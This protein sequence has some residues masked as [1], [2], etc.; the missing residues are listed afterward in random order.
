MKSLVKLILSLGIKLAFVALLIAIAMGLSSCSGCTPSDTSI[1]LAIN[2]NPDITEESVKENNS[3]PVET[4]VSSLK[5]NESG[6]N[7]T[8]NNT[9]AKPTE[10][11]EQEPRNIETVSNNQEENDSDSAQPRMQDSATP[12]PTP[13]AADVSGQSATPT[14][15][16][17]A[18][19]TPKPTNTPVPTATP[20]TKPTSTPV[21][22]ATPTPEPTEAPEPTPQPPVAARIRVTLRVWGSDD[23]DGED[24]DISVIVYR[25]YTVQPK[26]GCT[27]HSYNTGNYVAPDMQI[28]TSDINS[29]FYAQY[30]NGLAVGYA[31]IGDEIVGFV[32]D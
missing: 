10:Q 17:T 15:V 30:P 24:N 11:T 21:P 16:P 7:T 31:Y 9:V 26:D 5:A 12:T 22:T 19:A 2:Q 27:Y 32:D 6:S 3:D 13:K 23:P 1:S 8:R 18:T 29:E 14:P 25:T 20:T 4:T 28:D